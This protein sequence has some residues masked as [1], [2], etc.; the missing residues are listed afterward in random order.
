[1]FSFIIIKNSIQPLCM[2]TK[3]S[4]FG[5]PAKMHIINNS[6]KVFPDHQRKTHKMDDVIGNL[7]YLVKGCVVRFLSHCVFLVPT[8][9]QGGDQYPASYPIRYGQTRRGRKVDSSSQSYFT[10]SFL[11]LYGGCASAAGLC[12]LCLQLQV[13]MQLRRRAGNLVG[14]AGPVFRSLAHKMRRPQIL[15]TYLLSMRRLTPLGDHQ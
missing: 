8:R 4:F 7:S 3:N 2:W 6:L 9:S 14:V 1:M 12:R 13:L 10:P 15:H 11:F 5:S